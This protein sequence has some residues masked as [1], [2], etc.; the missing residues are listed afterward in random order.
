MGHVLMENRNGLV[1]DAALAHATGTAKRE[2]AL[3]MLVR[4]EGRHCITPGT[5]KA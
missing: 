5:D 4:L 1:V 3:T 2:A